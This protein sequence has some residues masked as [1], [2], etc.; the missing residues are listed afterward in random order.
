MPQVFRSMFAD[1]TGALPRIA[2]DNKSLGV[3]TQ[4][5]NANNP[6]VVVRDGFVDPGRQGMS[7]APTAE[8]LPFFLIPRRFV[9]HHKRGKGVPSGNNQMIC[10]RAGEGPFVDSKFA[11]QLMFWTSPAGSSTHGV[12]APDTVCSLNDYRNALGKTLSLWE[13]IPWPWEVVTS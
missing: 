11:E 9:T 4:D 10:W 5:E 2:N 3:R 13:L 6:D 1:E 7:V 8:D 12:I